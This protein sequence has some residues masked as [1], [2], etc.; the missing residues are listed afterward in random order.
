MTSVLGQSRA[1]EELL[2][3]CR[4]TDQESQRV[5]ARFESQSWP[6]TCVRM[7]TVTAPG[8]LPPVRLIFEKAGEEIV[9]LLDDDAEAHPDWLTR[10]VAHYADPSVGAVG[11]RC[12][13]YFDGALAVYPPVQRVARL[14]WYGRSVGNMYRDT[15]FEGP[16][17][18]DFLIGGNCSYR[19]D[20]LHQIRVDDRL[21]ANVS[22]HWEMDIGQQVKKRG[23]R[24]V[25]DPKIRV[26]HHTAPRE[27]EGMRTVNFEGVYWSN[28]N[29]AF[30]MR[31]HLSRLG[32]VA[33]V[34]WSFLIGGS[35]SPGLARIA[36]SGMTGRRIAW[37]AEV[38][39]SVLGRLAGMRKDQGL[40]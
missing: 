18:A 26:D 1:P 21:G 22:F 23:L 15:M 28:H 4:D 8:F 6:N 39:A 25:F 14:Y 30:L 7:Y 11:G 27:T 13:N 37:K 31:K 12:I 24:L 17:D 3:V 29:Y 16:C 5:V 32:F 36:Y 40:V 33:Y 38:W 20:V 35:G 2:V 19:S 9:A 10:I 34:A